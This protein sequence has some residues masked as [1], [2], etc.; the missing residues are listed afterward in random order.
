MSITF[1]EGPCSWCAL[2]E[3]RCWPTA[4]GEAGAEWG[5]DEGTD[6]QTRPLQF[7]L[8]L[9]VVW[10]MRGV[11]RRYDT[12][13]PFVIHL[14]HPSRVSREMDARESNVCMSGIARRRKAEVEA[15]SS[16]HFQHVRD[17]RSMGSQLV[18]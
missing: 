18:G 14:V 2:G 7:C 1:Q 11:R 13:P 16:S 15:V 3:T 8:D 4:S 6:N 9:E 12:P 17:K 5:N 10:S